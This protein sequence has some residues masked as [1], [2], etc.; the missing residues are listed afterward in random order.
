M[1]DQPIV[2]EREVNTFET[3][4]KKQVMI[5]A[6]LTPIERRDIR[7]AYAKNV[8]TVIDDQGN[9]KFEVIEGRDI[10]SDSEDALVRIAVVSYD[11]SAENIL[12]R[13]LNGPSEEHKFIF[14]K[15]NEI[16]K[17]PK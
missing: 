8:K 5:K 14:N 9:S 12:E 11:G 16:G 1:S 15:C 7:A 4:L 17:D 10:V 6:Y 13:L 3:P 2:P